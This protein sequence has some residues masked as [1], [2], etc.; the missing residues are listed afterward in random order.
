LFDGA[1]IGFGPVLARFSVDRPRPDAGREEASADTRRLDRERFD[2]RLIEELS[3]AKRHGTGLWLLFLGIDD[4][5]AVH[6]QLGPAAG[7]SA[8]QQLMATIDPVLHTDDVLARYDGAEFAILAREGERGDPLALAERIRDVVQTTR[9]VHET[10]PM[11]LTVS[12]GVAALGDCRAPS[13]DQ[14]V[15]LAD[16]SLH[17]AKISGRNCCKRF[18]SS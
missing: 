3:R 10:T 13:A 11:S 15:R 18:L 8:L 12:V 14:L 7:D 17:W 6:M 9:F 1:L 2:D 5:G 16:A 4:L